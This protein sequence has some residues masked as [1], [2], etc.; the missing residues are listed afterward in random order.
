VE[1]PKTNKGNTVKAE[2]TPEMIKEYTDLF[3]KA[4]HYKLS[5]ESIVSEIEKKKAEK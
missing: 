5:A 2:V 3:G 4:P 1:T